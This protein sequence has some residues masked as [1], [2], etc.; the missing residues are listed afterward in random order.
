MIAKLSFA[1]D[2]GNRLR[3]SWPRRFGVDNALNPRPARPQLREG[4]SES[5]QGLRQAETA[6]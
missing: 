4:Q 2:R 1:R 3:I 6:L 5:Q